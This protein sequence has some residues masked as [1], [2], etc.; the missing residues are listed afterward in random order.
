ME[1]VHLYIVL[2]LATGIGFFLGYRERKKRHRKN[3]PKMVQDYYQGLNYLLDEQQD[4][5]VDTFL[6]TLIVGNDT[7]ETH[8][9]L[10]SHVR[11][12]GEIDKAIRI[13]HK[14]LECPV[15]S[16]RN[17]A[18]AKLEIARDYLLAGLLGRAETI[19]L[20]LAKQK[21]LKTEAVEHLIE[22]YQRESDWEKAE[23][24]ARQLMGRDDSNIRKTLAH[25][26]CEMVEEKLENGDV[27]SA[28]ELLRRA[29]EYDD[30]CFR[31]CLLR[32]R[33]DYESKYYE[34]SLKHLRRARDLRPDLAGSTL[35]LYRNSC[36]ALNDLDSYGRFLEECIEQVP[37]LKVIDGVPVLEVV[38]ALATHRA[39]VD[40]PKAS[41]AFLGDQLLR[42][43]TLKGFGRLIE[44][45]E[46]A[47]IG[48]P[49]EYVHVARNYAEALANNNP[50][51]QCNNC[52]FSAR[53][54]L[55][56]C[57]SCHLWERFEYMP[58]IGQATPT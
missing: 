14:L 15:L 40:G 21:E 2:M 20:E 9:A 25:F 12:R 22:I 5:A 29:G 6:D 36:L 30:S 45:Y 26:V 18:W 3:L 28:R 24:V 32:A 4:L 44:E 17:S 41:R 50:L 16:E 53:T 38:D 7:F 54:L 48:V 34:E 43:P 35:E 56:Q 52:G 51:Y 47:N 11:R 33:T 8:V 13:H 31:V 55:W 19:L 27:Y 39:S 37:D 58:E 10:A 42:R 46:K 23:E 49:S 1:S 57:P